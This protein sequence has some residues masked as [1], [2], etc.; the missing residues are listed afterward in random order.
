[1]DKMQL[2]KLSSITSAHKVKGTA[3]YLTIDF[4]T[5]G[6][7]IFQALSYARV[8]QGIIFLG[9]WRRSVWEGEGGC[10]AFPEWIRFQVTAEDRE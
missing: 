5:Q 1:M 6:T 8:A 2:Q 3:I 4:K 9:K 10:E 7:F